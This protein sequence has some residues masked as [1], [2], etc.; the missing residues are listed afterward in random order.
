MEY[1]NYFTELLEEVPESYILTFNSLD[2]K[3]DIKGKE[4]L[5]TLTNQSLPVIPT[6]NKNLN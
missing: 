1:Y 5:L 6:V 2:G 3:A 4:Y